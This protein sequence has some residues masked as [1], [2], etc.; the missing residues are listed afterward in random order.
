MTGQT[1]RTQ[2]L[3]P[4]SDEPLAAHLPS[5][6]SHCFLHIICYVSQKKASDSSFTLRSC[7]P[8]SLLT[9]KQTLSSVNET[10]SIPR[11]GE[12]LRSL[13]EEQR[14]V[15]L[16]QLIPVINTRGKSGA[17]LRFVRSSCESRL[18]DKSR[19][20]TANASSVLLAPQR[21]L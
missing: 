19:W 17:L 1:G 11:P 12:T 9:F 8:S 7:F 6:D 15:H 21:A 3:P 10:I 20:A 18:S 4:C 5:P 13:S 2:E 16:L 14:V